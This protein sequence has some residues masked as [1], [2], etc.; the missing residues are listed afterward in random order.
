[1]KIYGG[2]CPP[3]NFRIVRKIVPNTNTESNKTRDNREANPDSEEQSFYWN[4][5]DFRSEAQVKIAEAL[6]RTNILFIPNFKIR[7][8]STEGRE[9]KQVDFLIFYQGK[10]GILEIDRPPSPQDE[11]NFRECDIATRRYRDRIF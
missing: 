7:L 11:A 8:T 10:S 9:N 1:M 2:H 6:D 4:G 5:L 3:N